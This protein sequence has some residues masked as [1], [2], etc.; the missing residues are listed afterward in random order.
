MFRIPSFYEM[1][2]P[3]KEAARLMTLHGRGDLLEG[4]KAM[5][6]SW[7]EHCHNPEGDD[8][9]YFS[10]YEYEVN[11]YNVVFSN[12]SKLFAPVEA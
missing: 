1:E 6:R 8:D 3:F 10:Y 9:E 11:A 2:M 7:V 4:M 12:M 5:D